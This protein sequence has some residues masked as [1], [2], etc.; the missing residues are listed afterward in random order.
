[1]KK[2]LLAVAA[3]GCTLLTQ[4]Q[5]VI[6]VDSEKIFKS[7]PEY[8]AA[9][10]AIETKTKEC[11]AEVERR[12]DEVEQLFNLY[13]LGRASYSEAKRVETE[14]LIL[15]KEK[16]AT[17][18][19]ESC[20]SDDGTI[21]KLRVELITPI[22]ERVFTAIDNFSKGKSIDLVLDKS[23]NPS[24]LYSGSTIDYTDQIISVL[25]QS[26]TTSTGATASTSSSTSQSQI[27]L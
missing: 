27:K 11:Q 20:F 5:S 12:F 7:M 2:L 26:T 9:L 10:T 3:I 14:A 8:S 21:M 19:Q 6:V 18:Y 23:A 1:M 22:Q 24:I 16:A 17:E 15:S 25:Q 13:S 4:A